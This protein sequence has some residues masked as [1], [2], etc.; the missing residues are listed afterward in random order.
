[1]PPAAD[2][3]KILMRQAVDEVIVTLPAKLHYSTIERVIEVCER[4]GVQVQYPEDLFDVSWSNHCHRDNRDQPQVVLKMVRE[5]YRH[6]IKRAID[7]AGALTG[8]GCWRSSL[9]YRCDPHQIDEQGPGAFQAGEIWTGTPRVL[10][11]QIPHH[12]RER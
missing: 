12:V 7:I 1:M 4:V 6:R 8:L 5:D 2:L 3:E 9:P 10:H 11:L